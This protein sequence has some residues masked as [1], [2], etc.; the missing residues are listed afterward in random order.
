M[1]SS[2]NCS[3]RE[4]AG[5][6]PFS[7]S[8]CNAKG[9]ADRDPSRYSTGTSTRRL[10][11]CAAANS[12]SVSVTT[13]FWMPLG[14]IG[15]RTPSAAAS[16]SLTCARNRFSTAALPRAPSESQGRAGPPAATGLVASVRPGTN[17]STISTGIRPPAAMLAAAA[18]ISAGSPGDQAACSGPNS[19]VSAASPGSAT[20]I[21]GAWA[22]LTAICS[23][24]V[25][26]ASNRAMSS[27]SPGSAFRPRAA[28]ELMSAIRAR[29]AA[30]SGIP[31]TDACS[32]L[33]RGRSSTSVGGPR[34][35]CRCRP[36]GLGTAAPRYRR[37]RVRAGA[38]RQQAAAPP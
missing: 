8:A 13:E 38:G 37:R 36:A 30:V 19:I 32:P 1:D 5:S 28:P 29:F 16:A 7:G 3:S 15:T 4:Q 10:P 18:W 11:G 20:E 22:S 9:C 31:T 21:R 23:R 17:G 12:R 6:C 34:C 33:I 24:R 26:S 14:E 27:R 25:A 2:A 35:S